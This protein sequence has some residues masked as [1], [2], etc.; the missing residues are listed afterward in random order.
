MSETVGISRPQGQTARAVPSSAKRP[1]IVIIGGG[2]GGIAAAKALRHCDAEIVVID[3]RNHHIFQPLLYQVATA[4]LAPSEVAAPIRQLEAK[5][6]NVSVLMA[7]VVGVDP[8][9][10]SIDANCPGIGIKKIGFDYLVV[11]AGMQSSYFGH[12]DFAEFAPCLKTITDAETIRSKILSAY[13]LAESTDNADERQ[14]QMTFVLVGAGPTGVELA[15]SIAQLATKTLR[16]NFRR[17][18]PATTT[19]ILLDGAKRI[20]PSLAESLSKKAADHLA[21]L[22][23]Q[24]ITGAMVESIDA[25]GVTVGGKLIP[26]GAV[27]WTAGVSP[28]P[29]VKMLGVA[30]D[31]AGRAC[32]GPFLNV[33]DTPATFVVGDTATLVQ[34]GKPL[35]GVAQVAIQQ[36]RYVGRLISRELSGRKPPRPFRYFDKGNMAVVGKNFAIMETRRIR[37]AGFTAWLAWAFIHLLFLP[38]LQN[39]LRVERQWMWTYFTGQRSSRLVTEAPRFGK[40]PVRNSSQKATTE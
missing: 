5:Q 12:D 10:R 4:V 24:V 26:C 36:G 11:A 39:R 2:F 37:L 1:R 38:Q 14:R 3:R 35:P 6:K 17:I 40:Y 21:K 18:D 7:E 27:L 30:T 8:G 28:S 15:A 32:V 19:I 16:K 34:E 29:L 23:V 31:R 20:L 13:E 22:G 33:P 9:S 25:Q